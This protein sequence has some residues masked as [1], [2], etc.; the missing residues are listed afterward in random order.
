MK[1]CLE[2]AELEEVYDL[3]ARAIDAVGQQGESLFLSK[4]VMTLAHRVGDVESVS[5]A[6]R[7]ASGSGVDPLHL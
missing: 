6:I 7:V 2:F 3:V 5:Q 4:L 1:K